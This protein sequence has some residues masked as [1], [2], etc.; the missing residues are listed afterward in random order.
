MVGN[1]FNMRLVIDLGLVVQ[2]LTKLSAKVTSK[3]QNKMQKTAH[4]FAAIISMYLK[5]PKYNK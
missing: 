5:I 4:T 1:G 3:L 2:N